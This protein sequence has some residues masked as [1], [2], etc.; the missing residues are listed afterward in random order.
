MSN[1]VKPGLG[2]PDEFL[3]YPDP[4]CPDEDDDGCPE[5]GCPGCPYI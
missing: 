1:T 3:D 5:G 4:E 2:I